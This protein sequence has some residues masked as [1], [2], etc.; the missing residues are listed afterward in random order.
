MKLIE[1]PTDKAEA[2]ADD[3]YQGRFSRTDNRKVL[4]NLNDLAFLYHHYIQYDG[5]LAACDMEDI[6]VRVNQTP[7]RN[8][9][10]SNSFNIAKEILSLSA[11]L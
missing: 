11:P 3:Y 10:G 8:L 6:I 7:Q 4:G 1:L 2:I 5:G 9:G